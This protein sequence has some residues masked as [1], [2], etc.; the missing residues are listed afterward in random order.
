MEHRVST[1]WQPGPFKGGDQ[2][3]PL[4][5]ASIWL[6][7]RPQKEAKGQTGGSQQPWQR[8][9]QDLA[10]LVRRTHATLWAW[11]TPRVCG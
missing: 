7:P 8:S 1:R 6:S 5:Q 3:H 2:S 11:M 9:P 10:L 4:P